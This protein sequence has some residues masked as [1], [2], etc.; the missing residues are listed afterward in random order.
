MM[1]ELRFP[2][3]DTEVGLWLWSRSPLASAALEAGREMV[4]EY[5]REL[6]RFLPD[7]ELGRLN[8]AA[9]HGPQPVSETLHEVVRLALEHAGQSQGLFDPTVLGNVIDYRRVRLGNDTIE[10]EE[11]MAL[12][13][14]GFAKGFIADRVAEEL[15]PVGPVLVDAGGDLRALGLAWPIGVQDPLHPERNLAQL[16]LRDGAAATSSVVKR[17]RHLIDPRTGAP[18]SS[19]VHTAVVVAPTAVQA[20]TAAKVSLLLGREAGGRYLA[21]QGLKGWLLSA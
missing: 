13:L 1:H 10:L 3:M 17:G 12:D 8:R 20:E 6:S 2:A 9:G 21:R 7:S 11:G 18:M 4:L 5:A 19:D 16:E 15:S 14:G